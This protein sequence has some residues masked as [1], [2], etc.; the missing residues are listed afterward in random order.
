M[1]SSQKHIYTLT[2]THCCLLHYSNHVRKHT[3]IAFVEQATRIKT[4][5]HLSHR[6]TMHRFQERTKKNVFRKVFYCLWSIVDCG[7]SVVQPSGVIFVWSSVW[8]QPP[9]V[10]F[11]DPTMMMDVFMV[12]VCVIVYLYANEARTYGEANH[13]YGLGIVAVFNQK[14][15]S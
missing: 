3:S 9:L 14:F 6:L 7:H 15:K 4:H 11:N 8:R 5:K 2:K 10:K 13:I 12:C 1:S